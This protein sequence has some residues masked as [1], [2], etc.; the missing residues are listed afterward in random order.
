MKPKCAPTYLRLDLI[1]TITAIFPTHVYFYATA[2]TEGGVFLHV[3]FYHFKGLTDFE[4]WDIV[5]FVKHINNT[6]T[7]KSTCTDEYDD[8]L[9]FIFVSH[10]LHFDKIKSPFIN[11]QFKFNSASQAHMRSSSIKLSFLGFNFFLPTNTQLGATAFFCL[12]LL[13]F[14]MHATLIFIW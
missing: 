12:T 8:T 14:C 1:L 10:R 7:N 5:I 3:I 6:L 11:H 2:Q 13:L 9:L 4:M